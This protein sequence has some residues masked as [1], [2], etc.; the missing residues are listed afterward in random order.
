MGL[1]GREHVT[2]RNG[3]LEGRNDSKEQIIWKEF[4]VLKATS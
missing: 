1:V 3:S 2:G 4:R